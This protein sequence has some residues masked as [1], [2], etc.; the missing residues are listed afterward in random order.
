[1][2]EKEGWRKRRPANWLICIK[3]YN[4]GGATQRSQTISEVARKCKKG[5]EKKDLILN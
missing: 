4:L 5:I 1:M 2:V 3:D